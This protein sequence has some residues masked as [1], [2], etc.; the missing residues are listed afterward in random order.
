LRFDG[1]KNFMLKW[2]WC[3]SQGSCDYF[4]LWDI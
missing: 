3:S 4:Y 1:L 2:T